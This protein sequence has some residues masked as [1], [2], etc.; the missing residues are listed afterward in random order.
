MLAGAP[1]RRRL[2]AERCDGRV[3]EVT[4]TATSSEC[5]CVQDLESSIAI[6]TPATDGFFAQ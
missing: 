4:T 6:E 5:L 3:F 1:N 2:E